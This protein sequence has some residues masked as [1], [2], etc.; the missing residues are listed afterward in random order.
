ME[1]V[2]ISIAALA[3]AAAF[4]QKLAEGA[5]SETGK[6]VAGRMLEWVRSRGD[7]D[8]EARAAIEMVEADPS[9][10][11][12][13]EEL[14]EVLAARASADPALARELRELADEARRGGSITIVTGP[15]SGGGGGHGVAGG[16]GGGTAIGGG[17]GG[18]GGDGGNIYMHPGLP[19]PPGAGGGGGGG[20]VVPVIAS[21]GTVYLGRPGDGGAGGSYLPGPRRS[22]A[23]SD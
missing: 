7:D 14:S 13:V 2:S 8:R 15:V 10:Q 21:D 5:A 20:G 4:A 16:G 11:R 22:P 9:K 19:E 12:R 3:V 17:D 6:T 23:D 18:R 1:P